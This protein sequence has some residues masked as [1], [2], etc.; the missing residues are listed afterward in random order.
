MEHFFLLGNDLPESVI[1][2]E[3]YGPE[4]LGWLAAGL[5]VWITLCLVY[6][7]LEP[8]GRRRM[9]LT[10][11]LFIL[12]LETFRII[13]QIGAGVFDRTY[14]PLH[15]CGLA[16][17]FT[18]IHALRWEPAAEGTPIRRNVLL[19]EILYSLCLPGALS[20]LAFPD[21]TRFPT[22]NVQSM[23][24]FM[25]HIFLMAYPLMLVAGG[26]IRPSAKRLPKCFLFIAV[27]AVPIYILNKVIGTNFFFLNEPSPG[28]P[29][30]IFAGPLGNPGYLL[31][32]IPILGTAWLLLYVPLGIWRR[33]RKC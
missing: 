12:A 29:L 9:A 27:L 18:L 33:L 11:S 15:L 3:A 20:A 14:L 8:K 22:L 24:S 7:R 5:A 28:S 16:T 30:E 32:Y 4:H 1:G 23:Q 31:G 21:W 13:L 26:D 17:Y 6:R 10:V 19:G 25:T 2:I